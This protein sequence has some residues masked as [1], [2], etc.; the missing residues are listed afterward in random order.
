MA[1]VKFTCIRSPSASHRR[2][3]RT[4]VLFIPVLNLFIAS[5]LANGRTKERHFGLRLFSQHEGRCDSLWCSLGSRSC[6][7]NCNCMCVSSG[8]HTLSSSLSSFVSPYETPR[9][10]PGISHVKTVVFVACTERSYVRYE[11]NFIYVRSWLTSEVHESRTDNRVC[12]PTP[13]NLYGFQTNAS[14]SQAVFT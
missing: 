3:V 14:D 8:R 12:R 6:F 9:Q 1:F 2:I 11:L 5:H 4:L 10:R 7:V 13:R